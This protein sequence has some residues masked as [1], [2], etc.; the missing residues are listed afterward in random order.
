VHAGVEDYNLLLEG[1]N[2]LLAEHNELRYHSE[3]LE[4]K[5]AEVC[6]SA[7][8]DIAALEAIIRSAEAHSVD[9]AADCE[10]RLGD[11]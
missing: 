6:S 4:S 9:I 10:N 5:L 7:V 3:D 2:S 11:F 1:N 8:E